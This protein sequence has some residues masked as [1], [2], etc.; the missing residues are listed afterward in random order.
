[1]ERKLT[2]DRRLQAR[3]VGV[4]QDAAEA[5]D[6]ASALVAAAVCLARHGQAA[7]KEA[8]QYHDYKA[9]PQRSEAQ[10]RKNEPR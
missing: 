2:A 10:N 4:Q 8:G 7:A 5:D 6:G 1:M 9:C 3:P